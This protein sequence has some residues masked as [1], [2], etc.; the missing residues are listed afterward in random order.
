MGK[1]QL[2]QCEPNYRASPPKEVDEGRRPSVDSFGIRYFREIPPLP[3]GKGG[4][5]LVKGGQ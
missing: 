4:Q 3:L 2:E 5:H 1:V